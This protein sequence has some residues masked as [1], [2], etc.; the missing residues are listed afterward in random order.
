MEVVN[1]DAFEY[2][3]SFQDNVFDM[4]VLDPDYQDWDS[5]IDKGLINEAIRVLKDTGNLICFTK[6]PL[7]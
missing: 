4:V 3:K 5:L 2:L 6:Q 1:I 7:V